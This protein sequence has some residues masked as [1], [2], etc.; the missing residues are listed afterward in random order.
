MV[1]PNHYYLNLYTKILQ[2]KSLGDSRYRP[3]GVTPEPEIR[4][5][6]VRGDSVSS[7][8]LISDGISSLLT[9]NE[10][11]DL[12]RSV[13]RYGPQTGAKEVIDFAEEL[14][15]ED[16]CTV[17]VIPLPGWSVKVRDS[18]KELR[19]YRLSGAARSGRQRRM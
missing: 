16:N 1:C 15:A 13:A 19:E 17:V 4:N 14:G 2:I 5:C 3:F 18:T 7:M 6:V 11:S 8:I 9:D 10:V 12:V